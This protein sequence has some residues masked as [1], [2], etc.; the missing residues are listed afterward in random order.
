MGDHEREAEQLID[1]AE[2]KLKVCIYIHTIIA[3]PS[4]KPTNKQKL[5]SALLL[6]KVYFH[7]T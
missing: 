1:K 5:I 4:N 3:V 6:N 2:K 7:A